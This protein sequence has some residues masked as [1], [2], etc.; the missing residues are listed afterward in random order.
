M[1]I[2]KQEYISYMQQLKNSLFKILPL[3]EEKVPTINKHIDSVIFEVYH[4]RE[5][6]PHYDGAWLVQTQ[7][8]LNGLKEECNID[9]N[10]DSVRGK[11]LTALDNID[12]QILY[13]KDGDSI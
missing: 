10:K 3:Y 7:A 11:V 6:T 9:D 4:V 2:K 5:I 13:F 1:T 8:V 12:K